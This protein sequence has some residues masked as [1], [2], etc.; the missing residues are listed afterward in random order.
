MPAP[1]AVPNLAWP[2]SSAMSGHV[3]LGP[4]VAPPGIARVSARLAVVTLP[5]G[6]TLPPETDTISCALLRLERGIWVARAACGG[7][8][9]YLSPK[10]G[11]LVGYGA[12]LACDSAPGDAWRIVILART[13]LTIETLTLDWV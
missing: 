8:G 5:A 11:A 4:W 2:V 7:G 12:V 9:S 1:A 6:L 3:A 10:T 13:P